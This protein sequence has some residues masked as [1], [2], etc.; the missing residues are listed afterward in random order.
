MNLRVLIQIIFFVLVLADPDL[1]DLKKY[2]Q[3]Y[4][5]TIEGIKVTDHT[6]VNTVHLKLSL[7][8]LLI[9]KIQEAYNQVTVRL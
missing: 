3:Q 9:Q 1:S 7:M 6:S 5:L 2:Q 8:Y 4:P